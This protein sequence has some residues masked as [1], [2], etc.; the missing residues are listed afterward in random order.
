MRLPLSVHTPSIRI[1]TRIEELGP[2]RMGLSS[3]TKT[4]LFGAQPI[5]DP[6]TS[7]SKS[8]TINISINSR[9]IARESSIEPRN[10]ADGDGR[11]DALKH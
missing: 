3:G 2:T 11:N 7:A 4:V 6:C 1:H 10:E 9:C 5:A 8:V